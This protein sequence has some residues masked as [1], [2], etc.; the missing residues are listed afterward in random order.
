MVE[1]NTSGV[2]SRLLKSYSNM[3]FEDRAMVLIM[4]GAV[5]LLILTVLGELF[6]L[7]PE[8]ITPLPLPPFFG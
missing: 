6:S 3:P 8:Q 5:L 1:E 7:Y 4:S 2:T